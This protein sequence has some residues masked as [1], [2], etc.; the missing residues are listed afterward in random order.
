MKKRVLF[1]VLNF[2]A[3]LII[4][5]L[6]FMQLPQFGALPSAVRLERIKNS[7][8]YKDGAFQ[9]LSPTPDL[10]EDVSYFDILKAYLSFPLNLTPPKELPYLK[11]DLK[12]IPD[13][14]IFLY[15]FGHSSYLL[16]IN[17]KTI[18]VDPVFSGHASPIK[19]F[20]ANF[21]GSNIYSVDDFPAIDIVLISHDHYDHLDYETI[22]KLK[23]KTNKFYTSLGV[24]AHL[25][26]WGI[27]DSSILEFDWWDS[28][29]F[30]S[31]LKITATPARHFSGRGFTRKKSLWSS[32]VVQSNNT[33]VFVGGDSGY[34]SSFYKIGEKFGP[35]DLAILECGQY[36][37]YWPYI[38]M[39]PN[40]VVQASKD[41]RAKVLMPVHWSKFTLA[42]HAWNE[43]II[44]LKK[45][46]DKEGVQ[47][48]TPII[49]EKVQ[50]NKTYPDSVWW[51][52]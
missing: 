28:A 47:L 15:W 4:S 48:C 45:F 43:P 1:Y 33:K 44:E 5:I 16:K 26:R 52:L 51:N 39:L 3:L 38:H 9:N 22:L 7:P 32:F 20:G 37:Q 23:E 11:S 13:T 24:G 14:G 10:A 2:I 17:G 12:N 36:N 21:K 40:E 34:D 19:F 42:L 49:G 27:N 41:L 6:L 18:L 46:A 8:N 25:N 35:F 29:Q 50:I 31:N 30:D